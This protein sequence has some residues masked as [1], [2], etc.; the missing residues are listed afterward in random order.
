MGAS[1]LAKIL[2]LH[3]DAPWVGDN[4]TPD[5]TRRTLHA[6]TSVALAFAKYADLSGE[7]LTALLTLVMDAQNGRPATKGIDEG[8]LAAL[9]AVGYEW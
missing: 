1:P 9:E 6:L 2:P 3:R 5:D 7:Q 4:L 8:T